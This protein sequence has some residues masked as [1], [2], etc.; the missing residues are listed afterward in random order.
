MTL[1]QRDKAELRGAGYRVEVHSNFYAPALNGKHILT[2]P[3]TWYLTYAADAWA[4]CWRHYL[5]EA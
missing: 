2:G 1:T 5:A 3:H 4:V